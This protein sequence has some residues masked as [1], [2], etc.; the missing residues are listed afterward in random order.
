MV[1]APQ[2]AVAQQHQ[3]CG[4]HFSLDCR[5]WWFR[6]LDSKF[7]QSGRVGSWF[8]DSGLVK[9]RE[10]PTVAAGALSKSVRAASVFFQSL[11]CWMSGHLDVKLVSPL[12]PEDLL[13]PALLRGWHVACP[14]FIFELCKKSKVQEG[15]TVNKP[16]T[17]ISNLRT[18]RTGFDAFV[19]FSFW[20]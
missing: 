20:S 16:D 5:D 11:L 2:N 4:R 9:N 6:E 8:R 12:S 17:A 3:S 1:G 18:R 7:G 10:G 19:C 15:R 14:V 13:D